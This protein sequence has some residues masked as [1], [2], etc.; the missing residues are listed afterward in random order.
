MWEKL[1]EYGKQ[2]VSILQTLQK[3][4]EDLKEIREELRDVRQDVN[5]LRAEFR[6][7]A[8]VVERMAY[9]I[10]RDRDREEAERRI[11]LLEVENRFLR[12]ERGLPP[13]EPPRAEQ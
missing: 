3:H 9:A 12:H 1:V 6:D 5:Q 7:L 10:Q 2:L 11:L 13:G 8:R 4:E